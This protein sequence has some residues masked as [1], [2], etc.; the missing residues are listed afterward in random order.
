MISVCICCDGRRFIGQS[1]CPLCDGIGAFVHYD[2][3]IPEYMKDFY[4]ESINNSDFLLLN[5]SDK[6]V[7]LDREI[8][9]YF[10]DTGSEKGQLELEPESPLK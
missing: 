3:D 9:E 5:P 2:D 10:C 8:H 4:E 1:E 7:F 6:R